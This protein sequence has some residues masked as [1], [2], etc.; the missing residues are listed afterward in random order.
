MLLNLSRRLAVL[1][2]AGLLTW[3]GVAPATAQPLIDHVPEDAVVY[4]GWA[5]AAS[6]ADE[7]A[8]STFKEVVDL[9][10]PERLRDAWRSTL[11]V[12]RHAVDD[13]AFADHYQHVTGMWSASLHGAMA[14][15]V[16]LAPTDPQRGDIAPPGVALLWQPAN[17]GHR[18]ELLAGLKFYADQSPLPTELITDGAVVGLL[19]NHP[20]RPEA[21]P[22]EGG[23]GNT[24]GHA[25]RFQQGWAGLQQP[26]PVVA[27]LDL[28]AVTTL[29][30][31]VLAQEVGDAQ[32]LQQI[33]AVFDV[34]NL[35]GLGPA[36]YTAG[37]D[38]R[39]WR[40]ETFVAAPAPRTGLAALLDAPALTADDL[41]I[42]PASASWV[43]AASFD[44]GR[45]MDLIREAVNAAG[46]EAADPFEDALA[47]VSGMINADVENQLIR[48][49][50]TSWTLYA[51][52]LAVGDGLQG[53]TLVNPLRDPEGVE[54]ALRAAQAL[55]NLGLMQAFEDESFKLQVHTQ[56]FDGLDVH[57][58]AALFVTPSWAIVDGRLVVGLYPHAVVSARDRFTQPG[59]ILD[60]D[61]FAALRETIGTRRLTAYSWV[62]LPETAPQAYPTLLTYE[63]LLTGIATIATGQPMPMILPPLGRLLPLLEPTHAYSWIDE[64][65]L[66]STTRAPFPGA[67]HFGPA[68][69]GGSAATVAPMLL[70][71]TLPALGAA[72]RTARQMQDSTQARGIHQ[73][74]VVYANARGEN[75]LPD[76]IGQLIEDNHFLPEYTISPQSGTDVPRD[77]GQWLIEDQADWVRA[78]AD[79][80]LVPG[81]T[82]D[83]DRNKIAVFLRPGLYNEWDE[84]GRGTVTYNDNSTAFET[85]YFLIEDQLITQT[86][87][88]MDQLIERQRALGH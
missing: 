4:F 85:D 35:E 47:Q 6:L 82:E 7:Y 53:V 20:T 41:A 60:H 9:I 66:H 15:Y 12:I 71:T 77:I 40:T 38:G 30:R 39:R 23:P 42:A 88:T 46:P 61:D 43:G 75:K 80:I 79:Y 56:N 83:L 87:L 73:A 50:G 74:M 78:H 51:D 31:D 57:T 11:P 69:G 21:D 27:Y 67:T 34:L 32:E 19:I 37:Y 5:G 10:E 54:R 63:S 26:G 28:P 68:N 55:G 25:P 1:F 62:N 52:P 45:L 17:A 72:R 22:I 64:D 29:V 59:S 81:L 49:L 33:N 36:L 65:G 16:T 76:D 3:G 70:G 24:L 8:Q 86:G 18:Q 44:L 48:G 13:P 2:A 58:F 84:A 14:A